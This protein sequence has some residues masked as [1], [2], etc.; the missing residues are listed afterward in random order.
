MKYTKQHLIETAAQLNG[1]S[2]TVFVLNPV[3]LVGV[4]GAGI[5]KVF[6]D[7]HPNHYETWRALCLAKTVRPGAI[8]LS[9]TNRGFGLV[10][11]PTK[12]HWRDKGD[13]TLIRK[14]LCAINDL[15]PQTILL[16]KVGA[17]LAQLNWSEIAH[18]IEEYVK[19]ADVIVCTGHL[20]VHPME[21][22][23]HTF[24]QGA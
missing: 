7:S 2:N 16:P 17:G 3:N 19:K 5:A 8:L 10:G 23:W 24:Y 12:H 11:F 1:D 13:M 9:Q 6:K 18:E 22:N 15:E 4:M 20:T 21:G 14:G